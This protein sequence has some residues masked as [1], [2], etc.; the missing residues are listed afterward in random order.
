MK[1]YVSF[2]IGIAISAISLAGNTVYAAEERMPLQLNDE[3]LALAWILLLTVGELSG[4]RGGIERGF[5]SCQLAR[6]ARCVARTRG[7]DAFFN[8]GARLDDGTMWPTAFALT[9][10]TPQDEDRIREL[11]SRAAG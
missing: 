7:R 5:S 10:L 9:S 3:Q 1:K 2:I 11:V 6:L 8:D 4:Q